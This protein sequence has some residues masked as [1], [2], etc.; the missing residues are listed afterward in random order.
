[1]NG[2]G[3]PRGCLL[4]LLACGRVVEDG[5]EG[6]LLVLRRWSVESCNVCF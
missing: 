2:K 1:M 4:S 3:V 5:K 6:L